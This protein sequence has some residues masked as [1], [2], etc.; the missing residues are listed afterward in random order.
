MALWSALFDDDEELG[1]LL[2][3]IFAARAKRCRQ[4]ATMRRRAAFLA[5]L[6]RGGQGPSGKKRVPGEAFSWSDHVHRLTEDQF[7]RRY[8]LSWPSFC[9]LLRLLDEDLSVVN[10]RRAKNGNNG[11][12]VANAVKLAM[13]LR[14]LAGGD[15]L[16]R[17]VPSARVM[18][19]YDVS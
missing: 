19:I 12:L 2:E 6:A 7:K 16:M 8:R 13:G 3:Q 10:P 5:S 17:N 9:K 11:E 1:D 4:A 15:P 18:C 14:Y